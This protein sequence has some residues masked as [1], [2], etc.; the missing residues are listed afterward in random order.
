M[1]FFVVLLT[2]A[3]WSSC[4]LA[5]CE[6]TRKFIITVRFD[7]SQTTDASFPIDVQSAGFRHFLC[8]THNE[9]YLFWTITDGRIAEYLK[10]YIIGFRRGDEDGVVFGNLTKAI[11]GDKEQS[12]DINDF[13]YSDKEILE[14]TESFNITI[15]AD[16]ANSQTLLSCFSLIRPSD[17]W[18]VGV[19]KIDLCNRSVSQ[20]DESP[21]S[22]WGTGPEILRIYSF[23]AGVYDSNT[24]VSQGELDPLEPQESVARLRSVAAEGYGTFNVTA[25]DLDSSVSNQEGQNGPAC[26]PAG[27]IV[28]LASGSGIPIERLEL[29]QHVQLPQSGDSYPSSSSAVF[30]F[31]HRDPAA[32]SVFLKFTFVPSSNTMS[33][34]RISKGHYI[35]VYRRS[36]SC[37]SLSQQLEHASLI[38]AM[39][40][41][42]G[43]SFVGVAG[44]KMLVLAVEETVAKGL[45]N[46]HTMHGDFFV[47][48]VRVSCYTTAVKPVTANVAL[49]PLRFSR[50]LRMYRFTILLSN[51]VAWVANSNSPIVRA[52][53]SFVVSFNAA[54]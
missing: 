46:P 18:F 37:V 40:V 2:V 10:N 42:P 33:H 6:G 31:S 36:E 26:F 49:I 47:N 54:L 19:A 8:V 53:V 30:A 1:H 44:E 20:N 28:N 12:N 13:K 45:Y 32:F 52:M 17:D 5:E 15:T 22:K 50:Q 7:W 14:P 3:A 48:N 39:Y 43:D 25:A 9:N 24:Y 51:I 35:Y 38:P 21:G 4:A 29:H 34:I 27:E 11:E 41:R 16:S 23:D